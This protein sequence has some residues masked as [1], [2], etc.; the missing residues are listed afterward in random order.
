MKYLNVPFLLMSSFTLLSCA[1]AQDTPTK[2]EKPANKIM[3]EKVEACEPTPLTDAKTPEIKTIAEGAI[4]KIKTPF[5]F[6]AR[7]AKTFELLKN[8]VEDLPAA[9]AIDFTKTAVVA[10]FA[11]MK[12]TG[13]Y[14]LIIKQ[15]GENFAVEILSPPK[16]AMVTQI[17][18]SPY[19][20][21]LVPVEEEKS[22]NLTV[23]DDFKTAMKIY[24]ITSGEF[25]YSGGFTGRQ[26]KFSAEGTI[27]LMQT[28][29][30]V[31]L[32]FNLSGNGTD[33]EMKLTETASGI[34]KDGKIEVPRLD[35]GSFSE[36]P[37]PPVKVSGSMTGNKLNLTFEPLPT[38]V[39]D[40][41]SMNGKLEAIKND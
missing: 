16:D 39:A 23:S 20:V 31:T 33:K 15:T 13:G 34:L 3:N 17:L 12:N 41:F 27:G 6:V 2:E 24:K 19:Q 35:A 29:D 8:S 10:A 28:G 30:L 1:V 4:S 32:D 11:G 25:A 22:L 40:G 14:S 26:K 37:K 21:T 5:I 7:D 36:G 9:S 38:T 18:T